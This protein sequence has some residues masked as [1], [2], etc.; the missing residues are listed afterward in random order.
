MKASSDF[1]ASDER[2]LGS[3]AESV[4]LILGISENLWGMSMERL[5]RCPEFV[6]IFGPTTVL[7]TVVL[8]TGRSYLYRSELTI[9]NNW[10][11]L[12]TGTGTRRG[13]E[14]SVDQQCPNHCS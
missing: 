5:L 4:V 13:G 2:G 1:L 14:W 7:A 6:L 8:S 10:K 9:P 11:L 3:R 12:R